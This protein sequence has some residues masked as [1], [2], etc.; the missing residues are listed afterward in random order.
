MIYIWSY[1]KKYPKWLLLDILGALLFVVVNLGLPTALARMIDQG[2]TPADKQ[3]LYFWAFIMFII[4]LLGIVGRITLAYA[5]GRLTTTMIRDMRNDMYDKLQEY[6]HHE[7]K[8]IGVSS[9]VTR[10][11]SDA[12][13]LM[14]FAEMS[15]RM[16]IVT[17]LMMVSSVIMVLVTSPSLAW[18]VV[19][20]IPFLILVIYYVA[21]KTR[22]LSEKQQNTLDKINQYVRENLTGLRVIRAFAR[23][24]FQEERFDLKNRSY[25]K[26]SNRLFKLTG[27]TEALFVQIIIIMIVAI[28]WFSLD[29]LKQGTIKIGDLVAFIE[30]SFHALFS[31]LIFANIFTMYPRMAVSSK[32]IQ[33]V[34]AMPISIDPNINGIKETKTKGY[35]EFDNVTFAYP[36]E[37]ES[38]VLHDISF[39][40]RPG[41][42]IAFIGSTGSGKS[43]LVNL[44]PRFY[45]VTLGRILVDGV[46]VRD[47]NLKALRQKIGFIPQKAL[48]FTG[49][50]GENLKYGKKDASLAELHSAAD[51]AQ[52]KEFIESRAEKFD[53]HLAEGGSNLSG[54]QKQRL[55]IAR[56]VVK[57]PDIYIFD[58]SF[59]ALDYKTDSLL[60]QRLKE[61]TGNST[62]LIVAQRV[63]TIM[64]ADQ[65][66]VLDE[67]E[68]VGRGSHDELMKSNAIYREIANSQ[69]NQ[70]SLTQE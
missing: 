6:S 55:S 40:A 70:Q 14:Q 26:T 8:K 37:T 12:F 27:L 38:P 60:R 57:K 32:R 44:I 10:M 46:D 66:I 69:L 50:I 9:L 7:Y 15:L 48:L 56:A 43:S 34:M 39:K 23:E 4:V 25:E 24:N 3:A 62:V 11:T 1:L 59:S 65:I 30:Y 45:D 2:I 64:N 13:V 16:G 33:E 17:P 5:S 58:D 28:V 42:T 61:V 54:G 18:I 68:I 52:A 36:G 31:F 47:Y 29:P 21:A 67:G 35:L 41:E 53:S 19:F 51:I 22:P 20:A 49:T 63:G